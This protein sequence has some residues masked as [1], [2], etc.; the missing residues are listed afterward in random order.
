MNWIKSQPDTFSVQGFSLHNLQF[1]KHE[2][3]K[4]QDNFSIKYELKHGIKLNLIAFDD[5]KSYNLVF[6]TDKNLIR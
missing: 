2:Q 5:S 1:K 3:E 4:I 6:H